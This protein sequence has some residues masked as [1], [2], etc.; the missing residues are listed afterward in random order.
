MILRL[1]S[2]FSYYDV[3]GI[4]NQ[5][6]TII[7]VVPF[8]LSVV[9]IID[10]S[11]SIFHQRDLLFVWAIAIVGS[12]V[13]IS[14]LEVFYV[15]NQNKKHSINNSVENG[16][17]P[18]CISCKHVKENIRKYI[19]DHNKQRDGQTRSQMDSKTKSESANEDIPNFNDNNSS[20]IEFKNTIKFMQHWSQVVSTSMGYELFINHLEKEF[21]VETL[22]FITEVCPYISDT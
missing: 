21:N 5:F 19:S 7:R 6:K 13:G 12:T 15:I 14:Y 1:Y 22:L 4:R 9:L 17:I 11:L 3:F 16:A 20:I 8:C 18:A 2:N 10:I